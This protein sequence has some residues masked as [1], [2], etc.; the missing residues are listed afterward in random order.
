MTDQPQTK[1]ITPYSRLKDLLANPEVKARFVEVLGKN[2]GAF[3]SS[4]LNAVYLNNSLKDCDPNSIMVS[5]LRA[6]ALDMPVDPNLG[7]AAIVPYKGQGQLQIMYKGMVQLAM[8]SGAYRAMNDT[9]IY[10]GQT[11]VKDQ[12][13]GRIKIKGDPLSKQV[14]GWAF[15]YQLNNGFERFTYMTVEEMEEHGKR[16]SKSYDLPASLWKTNKPAMYRKTVIKK[17]LSFAPM[18]ISWREMVALDEDEAEHEA[19]RAEE[20]I[21]EGTFSEAPAFD[22]AAALVEEHISENDYAARGLLA[23]APDE[24]KGNRDALVQWGKV[25]RAWR[26]L[27]KKSDEAAQL[28]T[29]GVI[30]Q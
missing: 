8:R 19:E 2:A 15:Y 22:P 11:V 3:L 16:Y 24:I 27:G 4:V 1:A 29:D 25:Y 21:I 12:L 26:D 6:A 23:K 18:S 20:S 5:A 28:A 10:Q 14:I 9:P 7:F 17:G 13:T 30:P